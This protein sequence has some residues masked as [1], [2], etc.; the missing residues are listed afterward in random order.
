MRHFLAVCEVFLK[1]IPTISPCLPPGA[2]L[3]CSR[4]RPLPSPHRRIALRF[5]RQGPFQFDPGIGVLIQ[6]NG[7]ERGVGTGGGGVQ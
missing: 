5:R 3:S 4:L 1:L 6:D 2:A 7:G